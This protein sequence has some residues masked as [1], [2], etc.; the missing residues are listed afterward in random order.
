MR[1]RFLVSVAITD[2][3][4][5]AVAM[6]VASLAVFDTV[7]PWN[8]GFALTG[9]KSVFPMIGFMALALI[10]ASALTEQMSGPGVPRPTY[11]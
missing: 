1:T 10:A 2:L 7:L 6:S 4:S 9:G 3:L 5:L 8:A 11:G